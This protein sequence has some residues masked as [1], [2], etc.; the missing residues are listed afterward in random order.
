M[1]TPVD[2]VVGCEGSDLGLQPRHELDDVGRVFFVSDPGGVFVVDRDVVVRIFRIYV[3]DKTQIAATDVKG[4]CLGFFG[5]LGVDF[6]E[7]VDGVF[8]RAAIGD[9]RGETGAVFAE[10]R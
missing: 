2:G 10:S 8:G 4:R 7:E 1:V 5:A 9:V 6:D 3:V